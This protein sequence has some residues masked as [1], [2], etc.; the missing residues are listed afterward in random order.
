MNEIIID[1]RKSLSSSHWAVECWRCFTKETIELS[2]YLPRARVSH[3]RSVVASHIF[4]DCT[5]VR[6]G[7]I[8]GYS[9]LYSIDLFP[10]ILINEQND[11]RGS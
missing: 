9:L 2:T 8:E 7:G 3:F 5:W 6:L 4:V 10:Q 11:E 1:A